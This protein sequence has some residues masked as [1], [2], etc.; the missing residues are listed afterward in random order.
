[1]SIRGEKLNSRVGKK[2]PVDSRACDKNLILS[3]GQRKVRL[4]SCEARSARSA[5]PGELDSL[6]KGFRL[7]GEFG[8][9]DTPLNNYLLLTINYKN[10]PLT[11]LIVIKRDV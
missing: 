1:M 4:C 8:S 3:I 5:H 10:I 7:H 2:F 6:T 9:S 11:D